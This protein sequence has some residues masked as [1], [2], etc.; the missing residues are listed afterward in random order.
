MGSSEPW[1]YHTS[2]HWDQVF[3]PQ[4]TQLSSSVS[5]GQPG[6][7]RITITEL[8]SS[9]GSLLAGAILVDLGDTV[10]QKIYMSKS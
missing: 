10:A 5:S 2:R 6:L 8:L 9:M 3:V 1:D 4:E 7:T